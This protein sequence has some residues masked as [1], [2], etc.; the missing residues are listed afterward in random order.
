MPLSVL[1]LALAFRKVAYRLADG[2]VKRWK[3][4]VNV[5]VQEQLID[6]GTASA[7][8]GLTVLRNLAAHGDPTELDE[9]RAVEFVL[10]TDATQYALDNW[11]KKLGE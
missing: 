9:R 5:A 8:D 11:R 7:I 6:A 3:A 10:M 4:L 2:G 1:V